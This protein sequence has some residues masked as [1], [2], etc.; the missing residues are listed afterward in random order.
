MA[1]RIRF[2]PRATLNAQTNLAG[3]VELVRTRFIPLRACNRFEDHAWSIE[4]VGSRDGDCK[5]VYFSQTGVEPREYYPSGIRRGPAEIPEERLLREPFRSFAKAMLVYLHAWE[6]SI[7]LGVRMAAFRYLEAALHEINGSTCPT[8]TTPEVLN[9]ACNLAAE[10]LSGISSYLRGK[11]LKMIYRY[12]VELRLVAVLGEWECPLREPPRTRNR[13]GK[14]FDAER[15]RKLPSPQALEAL[16]AIFSSDSNDPTDIFASSACALMLCDPSRSVEVLFAPQHILAQDWIDSDTGEVGTGL[17]W[18]PA[19]GAAPIIKT[20]IPSMRDMAVRAV[21][22]LRQL[23]AP[24][25]ALA[26]W[27]EAYPD[28][29]YLPPHLEYLRGRDRLD[30]KEMYAV[31]FGGDVAKRS[32]TEVDRVRKWLVAMNVPRV[33]KRGGG[34][35]T[36]AAFADLERAVLA[37]L[38]AGFPVMDRKTG[39][40]YS[41]ALCLARVG[42][43][44]QE[45]PVRPSVASIALNTQSCGRP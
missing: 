44:T 43:S 38:P 8:A 25:R 40:R 4:G 7:N 22:R 41:E 2:I 17:R 42:N 13:V 18:F 39:M 12:M 28:R 15:Q 5:F 32:K 24:A 6:E 35:G 20:V 1:E 27:Y 11:Q 37:R 34:G 31:L 3:F 21:D 33:S 23:S 26:R 19:K 16:A 14:Q 29:L 10:E 30:Q 9:C 45:Q 36:S